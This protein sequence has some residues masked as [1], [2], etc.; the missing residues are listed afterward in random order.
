MFTFKSVITKKMRPGPELLEIV[1]HPKNAR[2]RRV[3]GQI[4]GIAL[5]EALHSGTSTITSELFRCTG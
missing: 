1:Q 5:Y 4:T 2:W 3:D